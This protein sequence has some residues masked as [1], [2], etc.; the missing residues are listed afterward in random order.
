VAYRDHLVLLLT[1]SAIPRVPG[2][3]SE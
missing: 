1:P 3:A 2:N